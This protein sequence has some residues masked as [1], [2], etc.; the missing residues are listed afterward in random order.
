MQALAARCF[1]NPGMSLL[2][3]QDPQIIIDRNYILYAMGVLG[4]HYPDAV[5]SCMKNMYR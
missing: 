1:A 2:P 4:R 3:V 5:L